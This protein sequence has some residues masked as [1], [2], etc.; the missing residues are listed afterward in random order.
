MTTLQNQ[1]KEHS[2]QYQVAVKA[3]WN[4]GNNDGDGYAIGSAGQT[5]AQAATSEGFE[6]LSNDGYDHPVVCADGDRVIAVADA[7]G[8]WAVDVTDMLR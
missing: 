6:I 5:P 2:Y 3:A 8:P 4:R 1:L 7:N